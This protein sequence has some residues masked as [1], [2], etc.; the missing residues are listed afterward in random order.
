MSYERMGKRAEELEAEVAV[1]MDAAAKADAGEDAAFGRDKSGEE[2]PGWVG[3]RKRPAD[4]IRAARPNWRLR[5]VTRPRSAK[6]GPRRTRGGFRD[7]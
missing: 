5:Q 4:K 3:D 2:M 7:R 6:R 1:W